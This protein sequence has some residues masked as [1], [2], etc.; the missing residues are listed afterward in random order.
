[1]KCRSTLACRLHCCLARISWQICLY[2]WPQPQRRRRLE[3]LLNTA[4]ELQ[5]YL[6]LKCL[7]TRYSSMIQRS[8]LAGT[9]WTCI[10]PCNSIDIRLVLNSSVQSQIDRQQ[11]QQKYRKFALSYINPLKCGGIRWLHLEVFSAIQVQPTFLIYDI[12]AL[13]RSRLSARVPECQKLKM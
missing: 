2:A 12:R 4:R 6:R 11:Y 1:M 8:K 9:D 13:W 7:T 3:T 10:R 5:M